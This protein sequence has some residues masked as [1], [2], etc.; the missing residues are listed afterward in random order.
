MGMDTIMRLGLS[1]A[2][3]IPL[4]IIIW[5]SIL[6]IRKQF[7][8]VEDKDVLLE[9]LE[10]VVAESRQHERIDITWPV[11]LKISE[12]EITTETVNIS[13]SGAFII[14]NKQI[15]INE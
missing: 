10:A 15:P 4:L 13:I 1:A 2:I 3:S 8:E 6:F 14:C 12:E 11:K 5:V 9:K 7:F